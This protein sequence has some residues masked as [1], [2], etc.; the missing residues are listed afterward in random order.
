MLTSILCFLVVW[1]GLALSLNL[2]DRCQRKRLQRRRQREMAKHT[3]PV[4]QVM[5]MAQW[6][7]EQWMI[8]REKLN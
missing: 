4:E 2:L 5:H 6:K 3:V 7:M 8:E 1:L